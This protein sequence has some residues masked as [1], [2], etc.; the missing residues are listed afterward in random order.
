MGKTVRGKRRQKTP[1]SFSPRNLRSN[2]RRQA[3]DNAANQSIGSTNPIS[4]TSAS[5]NAPSVSMTAIIASSSAAVTTAPSVGLITT[6]VPSG[7]TTS[8]TM[9][10]TGPI[11]SVGISVRNR[12]ASLSSSKGKKKRTKKERLQAR[13][14]ASKKRKEMR[15]SHSKSSEEPFEDETIE[16]EVSSD[17]S[18]DPAN[19]NSPLKP[20]SPRRVSKKARKRARESYDNDESDNDSEFEDRPPPRRK[21]RKISLEKEETK[22]EKQLRERRDALK[23]RAEIIKLVLRFKDMVHH[24]DSLVSHDK[25]PTSF[26]VDIQAQLDEIRQ[27]L[28]LLLLQYNK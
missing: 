27:K 22:E 21:R 9:T 3:S 15:K 16:D 5:S 12:F 10:N 8:T 18:L 20:V 28:P 25:D 1:P 11:M 13:K 14:K 2:T 19:M 17:S 26:L 7:V 6:A 4:A 23:I 24:A